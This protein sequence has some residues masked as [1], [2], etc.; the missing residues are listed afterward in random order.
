MYD[1]ETQDTIFFI[2]PKERESTRIKDPRANRR[3]ALIDQDQNGKSVSLSL[4]F[5]D[6]EMLPS[7]SLSL[8]P[9]FIHA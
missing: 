5:R 7:I 8:Y 9:V 3:R 4:A 1:V 2:E 6:Y